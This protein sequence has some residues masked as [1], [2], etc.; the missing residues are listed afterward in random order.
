MRTCVAAL[1]S[2]CLAV[3]CI[4]QHTTSDAELKAA[5]ARWEAKWSQFVAAAGDARKQGKI[6]KGG[7]LPAE[8]AAL[9][10]AADADREAVLAAFGG[11]S[12][13][14]AKSYLLLARLHEQ[15]RDYGAAV[16]AYERSLGKGGAESPD[17]D[18]L[19][20]LCI[21]AMNSKD[22]S[23]AAKWMRTT[24]DT[25]DRSGAAARRNLS[26]RTSFYPRT[27]IALGNWEELAQLL[28]KL[29]ADPRP[30]CKAAAA[31]FGVVAAI[32]RKDLAA[33]RA[34]LAEIRG[35]P[36]RFPDHQAWAVMAQ[37]ALMVH[38]GEFDAGAS[39]VRAFLAKPAAEGS[40]PMDGNWRRYLTA[41]EPFLGKPAPKLRVDHWVGGEV[42]GEDPLGALHGKVVVLDFWQPWCEP[43]RKAMPELV[44]AQREHAADLQL[45]GVCKVENYGYDVSERR[46]VRPIAPEDYAAHIADFRQ[47][48]AL[49]YPVALCATTDNNKTYAIAGVP[50]LV[51]IDRTGIVRYM[52]CGAG[53]PGLFRLA[54]AGVLA[55]R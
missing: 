35:E 18:T 7:N 53:E 48:M 3:P 32:H 1:V 17:L 26:V 23:L 38:G 2:F 16:A 9:Q 10:A 21:A 55:A 20:S 49:N 11:R 52:S 33:A 19:G 15:G 13:L 34:Q 8:V 45:L 22:D 42:A 47:D 4:A 5:F 6:V 29:A 27:L 51:V 44:A 31:T 46:A 14:T 25:E 12:D 41:V 54:L 50:T 36:A 39:M 30:E 40:S 37:F 43:C 24:I 28:T